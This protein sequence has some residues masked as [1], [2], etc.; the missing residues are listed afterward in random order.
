MA[1]TKT[2]MPMAAWKL[3][4][5]SENGDRNEDDGRRADQDVSTFL[6]IPYFPGDFGRPGTERALSG[7]VIGWLCPSII[8]NDQPGQ[9]SFERGAQTKVTV[10][11]GNYGAGT[12]TAPVYVRVWWSDPTAGFTVLNLF[13][14]ATLAVPNGSVKR[15]QEIVG[16]IPTTAPAHVCLL[17]R[18]WSPLDTGASSAIPDPINDRHCAQLNINEIVVPAGQRFQFM[19][20]AGNPS[21]RNA[22]F[23]ITAASIRQESARFLSRVRRM[24]HA[25]AQ[26]VELQLTDARDVRGP[27]PE[28]HGAHVR[29]GL[30]AGG[31]RSLL[32]AGK[33]PDEFPE[34]ATAVLEIASTVEG[35]QIGSI[36]L[37]LRKRR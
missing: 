34:G 17:A 18:V 13:G 5:R 14:Q 20:W 7:S 8:V 37:V 19:F 25:L 35:R 33:L 26:P 15:T 2:G 31:R 24:D 30:P 4:R 16:V 36:G 27:R 9:N 23:E 22:E 32:L 1:L 10:D 21:N 11:V 6:V 29:V 3:G 28:R 12:L